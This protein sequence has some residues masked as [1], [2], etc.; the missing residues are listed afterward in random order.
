MQQIAGMTTF[1]SARWPWRLERRLGA[2]PV[3]RQDGV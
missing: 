1:V 2:H 3:P